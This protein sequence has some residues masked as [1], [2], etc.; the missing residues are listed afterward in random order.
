[1]ESIRT[2]IVDDEE[3]SRVRLREMLG[4]I[5][6]VVVVG[7]C[8]D[9]A[10]AVRAIRAG[11]PELLFLD[12]Q[13]PRVGGFEVIREV[14]PEA[15]PAVIFV[16]AFDQFALQAFEAHALDYLLKPF[17]RERLA[18]AV[19]RARAVINHARGEKFSRRLEGLLASVGRKQD[20]LTRFEVKARGR[21]V[22]LPADE[23]DW[24][25][26]ASNYVEL[27]VGKET[28]L[29]RDSLGRLEERLDPAR[30]ARV[31]RSTIINRDRVAELSPLFNGDYALYLRDGTRLTLSRTYSEQFLSNFRTR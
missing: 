24:I 20:Y 7:E 2:L 15:V 25:A 27:H 29:V 11:A 18:W 23:I 10:E 19:G 26:A 16:T 21:I 14:G 30:F 4:E 31:H 6:E 5:P 8:A 17:G 9:G 3:P 22:L 12:I 1:M 28:H 13:M